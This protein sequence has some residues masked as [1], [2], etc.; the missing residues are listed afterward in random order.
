MSETLAL[1]F[2]SAAVGALISSIVNG[3]FNRRMKDQEL[4][5]QDMEMA[6]KMAELKHRQMIAVQPADVSFWDPLV[7]M[8]EY[9][10]G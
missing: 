3:V 5:R 1:I 7:T 6:L 4:E 2:G 10:R 9:R 8:I